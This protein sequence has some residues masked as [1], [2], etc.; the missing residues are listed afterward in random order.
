[1]GSIGENENGADGTAAVELSGEIEIAREMA[2]ATGHTTEAP[3]RAPVAASLLPPAVAPTSSSRTGTGRRRTGD[4]EPHYRFS[5][6]SVLLLTCLFALTFAAMTEM[7]AL[8]CSP[9]VA[10]LAADAPRN[11]MLRRTKRARGLEQSHT[12][13]SPIWPL[14]EP[15]L[16]IW[17]R[18]VAAVVSGTWRW[19]GTKVE[20]DNASREL[21]WRAQLAARSGQ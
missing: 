4:A 14:V 16:P 19:V 7:V 17:S 3:S 9:P 13:A 10:F 1:M 21:A 12:D 18:F 15:Q 5:V 8:E 11:G 2:R 20:E 6:R